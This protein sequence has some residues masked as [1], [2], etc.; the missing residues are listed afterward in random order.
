YIFASTGPYATWEYIHKIS[1]SIPTQRKLKDHVEAEINHFFRGKA[2]TSPDDEEDIALLQASYS[3]SKIHIYDA[4]RQIDAAD[5]VDDYIAKGSDYQALQRA[6]NN[7]SAKRTT[8]RAKTEDW[9]YGYELSEI[10]TA[11]MQTD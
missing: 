6:I 11:E 3:L 2:H 1:G 10:Q 5:K 9:T 4:K 7:W 8:T